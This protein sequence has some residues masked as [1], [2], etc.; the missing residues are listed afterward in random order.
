MSEY[1]PSVSVVVPAY[2]AEET[3]GPLL[4][5]LLA[6]DYPDREVIIV[7]DGSTDGTKA[8]VEQHPMQLID[9]PNRG[10]SAARDAGLRAAIGEIVAYVDSDVTVTRDWLRHL[11]KPLSEPAI[12]ATTGQTIFLRN[13]KATSWMRSLD[14]E[15]RNAR[16]KTYTRLAN[17]PN[18]A[19]RR[20]VLLEVGGFD[21]NWFHAEDTEVSYR[22]GQR[23]YKIRYV[24]E[25]IVHHM[26]EEDWRDFLRKRYRDAKAFTRMLRRYS[27]YAV[28]EDDFVSLGMKVQPPLFLLMLPLAIGAVFFMATPVGPYLAGAVVAVLCVAMGLNLSEALD[29]AKWSG[30]P[31]FFLKGMGLGLLRGFAW[32]AGLGVGGL[33]QAVR[34]KGSG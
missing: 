16:R 15:R 2:N 13:D 4:D 12:A 22:I 10:A 19:F 21:P 23:G 14:I 34:A 18:S 33:R 3:I 20:E 29:L 30:R 28:R 5:S 6:L 9:Q 7:N 27:R 1:L 24:P 31:S 11:V 25:A 8:I 26:P 32:G 17:G